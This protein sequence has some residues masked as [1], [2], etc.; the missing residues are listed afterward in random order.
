MGKLVG[1][2]SSGIGL[3][4]EAASDYQS[5]NKSTKR[6]NSHYQHDMTYGTNCL[7]LEE[8]ILSQ[9]LLGSRD[10]YMHDEQAQQDAKAFQELQSYADFQR[11]LSD[12]VQDDILKDE[13]YTL[14]DPRMLPQKQGVGEY[15]FHEPYIHPSLQHSNFPGRL[16]GPV[17][18]PQRRLEDKSQ[19]WVRAYDPALMNCGIDE[20]TFL[21]FLDAFNESSQVRSSL[22][23]PPLGLTSFS[24]RPTSTSST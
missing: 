21:N 11:V 10:V 22:I 3:A 18:I 6:S 2:L 23:K 12:R 16:P 5:S 13:K 20:H 24:H 8:Q 1:L 14:I 7:C 9:T 4:I 17:I 19:G 15:L